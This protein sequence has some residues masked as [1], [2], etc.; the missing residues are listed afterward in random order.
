IARREA[1]MEWQTFTG[2]LMGRSP[3]YLNASVMAMGAAAD[4][5]A[6][7]DPMFAENAR[8]YY[9]YARENDLSLMHTLIHSHVNRANKQ[10]KENRRGNYRGWHSF[11]CYTRWYHR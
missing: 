9:E 4:F 8:K 11:T 10:A 6:E 7:G 5:Y 2:G 1:I 3:D